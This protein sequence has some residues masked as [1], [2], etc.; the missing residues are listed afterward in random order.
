MISVEC[1]KF[2]ESYDIPMQSLKNKEDKCVQISFDF[3][4][5]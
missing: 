2:A 4:H 3:L 5:E 1:C